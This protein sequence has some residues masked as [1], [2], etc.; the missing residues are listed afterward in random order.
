MRQ[1]GRRLRIAITKAQAPT[2]GHVSYLVEQGEVLISRVGE[3]VALARR[4]GF[5]QDFLQE[6]VIQDGQGQPLWYAHFHYASLEAQAADFT[7]GHLKTREQRFDRAPLLVGGRN[8][9]AVIQVYRSRIDR[10]SAATLFFA[11]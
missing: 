5:A 3:R 8:S 2:I 1:E 9:Q 4:K 11:V 6:Y 7:A 10:M